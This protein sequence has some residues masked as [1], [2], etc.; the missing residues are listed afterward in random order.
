MTTSKAD[1]PYGS[2]PRD[3]PAAEAPDEAPRPRGLR[4]WLRARSPR[5]RVEL[6]ITALLVA[7]AFVL[8]VSALPSAPRIAELDVPPPT[9]TPTVPELYAK[10]APTV[11]QVRAIVDDES[12]LGSGVIIDTDGNILT[13]LHVVQG[14]RSIQ[15]QF[16]DGTVA[17]AK[18]LATLPEN[19]IAALQP[20]R[21]RR[22]DRD[23][24]GESRR[25][26]VVQRR[27]V[28]RDDRYG[29]RRDRRAAGLDEQQHTTG[30]TRR[31]DRADGRDARHPRPRA[32]DRDGPAALR[33]EEG[34]RRPGSPPR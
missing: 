19:D 29:R 24:P 33:G 11:V 26:Q 1:R 34:H 4:P 12:S 15:V 28:R 23:R 13:A 9:P 32:T 18:I 14:A 17:Q 2:F 25:P 21:R 3:V 7:L 6:A 22:G 10:L 8:V 30:G 5:E 31:G 16:A 20:R 27:G